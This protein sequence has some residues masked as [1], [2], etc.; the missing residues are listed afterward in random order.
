MIPSFRKL[1][2]TG[3]AISAKSVESGYQLLAKD[4]AGETKKFSSFP[5]PNPCPGIARQIVKSVVYLKVVVGSGAGTDGGN[6][7]E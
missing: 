7:L 3:V 2:V 4:W 6:H 5:M 1:D